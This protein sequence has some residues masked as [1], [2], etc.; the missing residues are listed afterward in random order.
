MTCARPTRQSF[1][2]GGPQSTFNSPVTPLFAVFPYISA[3]SALSSAFTHLHGGGRV[4]SVFP[5]TNFLVSS[6]CFLVCFQELAASLPS[7]CSV[8]TPRFLCFQQLTGSFCKYRGV[9]PQLWLTIHDLL[10]KLLDSAS[11]DSRTITHPPPCTR[12]DWSLQ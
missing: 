8:S 3:V 4:P 2:I 9:A 11:S 5:P 7:L 6:L 10:R 12:G 1:S